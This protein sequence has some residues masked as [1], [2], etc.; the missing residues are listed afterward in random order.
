MFLFKLDWESIRLCRHFYNNG[1]TFLSWK[2]KRCW[3]YGILLSVPLF[4]IKT[5]ILTP[6]MENAVKKKLL[7]IELEWESIL[8]VVY[9]NKTTNTT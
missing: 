8:E 1:K 4:V 6:S 2:Q 9:I 3:I 7:L 5:Q